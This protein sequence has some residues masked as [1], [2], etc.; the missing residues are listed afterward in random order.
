[1][2]TIFNELKQVKEPSETLAKT[3]IA[4]HDELKS[5][6]RV[7]YSSKKIVRKYHE[8]LIGK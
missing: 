2:E 1:M 5:H 3:G 6:F 8:G 4:T 7:R